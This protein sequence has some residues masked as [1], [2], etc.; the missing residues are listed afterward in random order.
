[1]VTWD[2][3]GNLIFKPSRGKGERREEML[4]EINY[5]MEN[6]HGRLVK[7]AGC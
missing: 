3:E 2:R 1:V 6:S 4:D 5:W 7:V